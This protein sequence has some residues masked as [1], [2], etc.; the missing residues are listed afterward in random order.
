L[1][2]LEIRIRD[3]LKV[4]FTARFLLPART[5]HVAL[6][7]TRQAGRPELADDLLQ[8]NQ[9]DEEVTLPEIG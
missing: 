3:L 7:R 2:S 1:F 6:A 4:L 9:A 5:A 8:H